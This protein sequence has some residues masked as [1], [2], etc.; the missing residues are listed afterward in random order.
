MPLER[1]SERVIKMRDV[2]GKEQRALDISKMKFVD[3]AGCNTSMTRNF[4]RSICGD[5]AV[6]NIPGGHAR[7]L[8]MIGMLD[9]NGVSAMMTIEGGTT[10]EVFSTFVREVLCKTL[11]PGD[12]VVMDNLS[13]HKVQGIAEAIREKGADVR[14][15]PPYSPDFNPIEQCWSKVKE[16]LRS[17]EART[18]EKL[19]EAIAV[20][21]NSV[22]SQNALSWMSHCGYSI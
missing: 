21:I 19:N 13:S 8:T 18:K 2:F 14:Y 12:I 7:N 3:E 20:A 11:K 16:I 15:L 9:V 1:L 22:T 10:G 17:M 6:G 5:K 4:A